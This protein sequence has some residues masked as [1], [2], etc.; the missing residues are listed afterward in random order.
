VLVCG[1][2]G[3]RMR[4]D[5]KRRKKPTG[6]EK[7]HHYYRCPTRQTEGKDACANSKNYWAEE[8]EWRVWQFISDLLKDPTQSA[9]RRPGHDDG[10]KR[11]GARG[12]P[13]REAKVWL[14]KLAALDRKRSGY[15]DLAVDG[16]MDRD[17][18][19]TKS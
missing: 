3:K 8:I 2:C 5:R 12:D 15:I 10:A 13:Q 14:D 17:E 1:G 18:L 4:A 7:L 9:T 16:I 11:N 6:F 19:R